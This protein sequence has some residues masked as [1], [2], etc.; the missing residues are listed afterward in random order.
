MWQKSPNSLP[1]R[2]KPTLNDQTAPNLSPDGRFLTYVSKQDDALGDIYWLRLKKRWWLS[3]SPPDRLQRAGW[4]DQ[5]PSWFHQR[6]AIVFQSRKIDQHEPHLWLADWSDELTTRSLNIKGFHPTVSPDDQSIAFT[7]RGHLFLYN[8]T[9]KTQHRLTPDGAFAIIEPQFHPETGD[10]YFIR[11][12]DD[13]NEDGLITT[14]DHGSVW[15]IRRRD[16]KDVTFPPMQPITSAGYDY[17]TPQPAQGRLWVSLRRE[18]RQMIATRPLNEL[19]ATEFRASPNELIQLQPDEQIFRL[20]QL[21]FSDLA[22][23]APMRAAW[24]Q[25]LSWYVHHKKL[26]ELNLLQAELQT[27]ALW[28]RQIQQT[29]QL[30]RQLIQPKTS[31]EPPPHPICATS[32]QSS[33]DR[34]AQLNFGLCWLNQIDSQAKGKQAAIWQKWDAWLELSTKLPFLHQEIVWRRAQYLLDHLGVEHALTSLPGLLVPELISSH[35]GQNIAETVLARLLAKNPAQPLQQLSLYLDRYRNVPWLG[36]QLLRATMARRFAQEANVVVRNEL[37]TL[38]AKS[39]EP[40]LV[41]EALALLLEYDHNPQRFYRLQK[42]IRQA[43]TRL[44][45]QAHPTLLADFKQL[46]SEKF[47]TIGDLYLQNQEPALAIEAFEESRRYRPDRVEVAQ[48]LI[49]AY[50]QKGHL[51]RILNQLAIT[52][53]RRNHTVLDQYLYSYAKTYKIDEAK[54]LDRRLELIDDL[55]SRFSNHADKFRAIPQAQQTRGWLYHQRHLWQEKKNRQDPSWWQAKLKIIDNFFSSSTFDDL[56]LANYYYERAYFHYKP[57]SV[58]RIRLSQNLGETHFFAKNYRKSLLFYRFRLTNLE[59]APF[60]T[61]A[62]HALTLYRAG[63][64]A[65]QQTQLAMATGFLTDASHIWERTKYDREKARS[66]DLLALIYREQGDYKKAAH[67]Y[68]SLLNNPRL[69]TNRA[70][71]RINYAACLLHLQREDEALRELELANESLAQVDEQDATINQSVDFKINLAATETLTQGFDPLTRRLLIATYKISGLT[72]KKDWLTSLE[73]NQQKIRLLA[74]KRQQGL[75]RHDDDSYQ[76][77]ELAL[78]WNHHGRLY[79][80]VGQQQKAQSALEQALGYARRLRQ[81]QVPHEIEWQIVNNLGKTLVH[82][83]QTKGGTKADAAA[84]LQQLLAG[85]KA[86]PDESLTT[87]GRRILSQLARWQRELAEKT[88]LPPTRKQRVTEVAHAWSRHLRQHNWLAAYQA[89]QTESPPLSRQPALLVD[90]LMS[91]LFS[92]RLQLLVES[93]S[94]PKTLI[95]ALQGHLNWRTRHF[96]KATGSV[97]DAATQNLATRKTPDWLEWRRSLAAD[98]GLGLV[99]PLK[100]SDQFLIAF[101]T[102]ESPVQIA[103]TKNIFTWISDQN[104]TS[105]EHVYLNPFPGYQP[106]AQTSYSISWLASG[107]ELATVKAGYQPAIGSLSYN[108]PEPSWLIPRFQNAPITRDDHKVSDLLHLSGMEIPHDL[109]ASRL[110]NPQPTLWQDWLTHLDVRQTIVVERTKTPAPIP[111]DQLLMSYWSL[112]QPIGA[113]AAIIH[114]APS[115]KPTDWRRFYSQFGQ[116]TIPHSMAHLDSDWHLLGA[117]GIPLKTQK[118]IARQRYREARDNLQ[119]GHA[120]HWAEVLGESTL[121]NETLLELRLNAQR[122][123]RF[124]EAF[125]FQNR[126][127][128]ALGDQLVGLDRADEL[129]TAGALALNADEPKKAQ[130]FLTKA[131]E[132][133]QAKGEIWSRAQIPFFQARYAQK[134]GNYEQAIELHRRSRELFLADYDQQSAAMRLLDIA[135]LKKDQLNNY[136]AA[137]DDYRQA[138]EELRNLDDQTNLR[139]LEIDLA[140]TY[141]AMGRIR[142]AIH[143]LKAR[144]KIDIDVA[145]LSSDALRRRLIL[146]NAY[147]RSGELQRGLLL[148]DQLIELQSAKSDLSPSLMIDIWNS[149]ALLLEKLSQTSEAKKYFT[150]ALD[151]AK[152]HKLSG[153]IAQISSNYGYALRENG[154]IEEAITW[155]RRAQSID[156]SL[157]DRKGL[158]FDYRNLALCYILLNQTSK[159]KNLLQQSLRISR[160]LGLTYNR[161]YVELSLADLAM[162]DNR[163]TRAAEYFQSSLKQARQAF[164]QEFI[165]KSLAGLAR[166]ALQQNNPQAGFDLYEQALALIEQLRAQFQSFEVRSQFQADKHIQD[167]YEEYVVALM[168]HDK[169]MRAWEISERS[170]ARAFIDSLANQ[171]IPI[172]NPQLATLVDQVKLAQTRWHK[173]Q[174]LLLSGDPDS[175]DYPTLKQDFSHAQEHYKQLLGDLKDK[176]PQL[177]ATLSIDTIPLDKLKNRL[178]ENTAA[179]EYMVADDRLVI[180]YL[181]QGG[182]EGTTVPVGRHRLRQMIRDYQTLMQNYAQV[183]L[184]AEQLAEILW[185]PFRDSLTKYQRLIVIP[186]A[187]LHYLSFASLKLNDRYLVDQ[188]HLHYW[189]SATTSRFTHEA[190]SPPLRFDRQSKLLALG[191]P[192]LAPHLD[193]PFAG[194][195][196]EV[197]TRY[198][199]NARINIGPQATE[200]LVKRPQHH[201]AM[202]HIASHGVFDKRNP[203]RSALLLTPDQNTDGRLTI[204]DIY[205]LNLATNLVTLSA[206]ETGLGLLK[207]ADEIVSLNRAFIYAGATTIISSLWRINDVAS[208]VIMKRFYRYLSQGLAVDEALSK[209]QQLVRS[210]YTHPAYWAA[211]RIIGRT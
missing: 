130:T 21:R 209:A 156:Q 77:L 35:L 8:L 196:V 201:F 206:C 192:K 106:G 103:T 49:D 98:E 169:V 36:P 86:M 162:R 116:T 180:W 155:F 164:I 45:G 189:E 151:L 33:R 204:E 110:L 122:Q 92:Y 15:R 123:Q 38:L 55:L 211:F 187:E 121:I 170:R 37:D 138:A 178:P 64:A 133:Y 39:H 84:A 104:V 70:I 81:E 59:Q 95:S 165:W 25:E 114:L 166:V 97:A 11:F 135:N 99:W 24:I 109:R 19:A 57:K 82:Q 119:F 46:A 147:Y 146:I 3:S 12:A 200:T 193:L 16:L 160:K 58:A 108:E 31:P 60:T 205:G 26:A 207:G 89:L 67:L 198:F 63:Y 23:Q 125:Y 56:T 41:R 9:S 47:R 94:T 145:E 202:L 52:I 142:K 153:K 143:L 173:A 51:D 126:L 120:L 197:M 91:K 184:M 157:K 50:V 152:S 129:L 61:K 177:F 5:A 161:I 195:E 18:H 20:R 191:N 139:R 132:L 83:A 117:R 44:T 148:N 194:K 158:A 174:R 112:V 136:H 68:K 66:Q 14:Q 30:A 179:L 76:A 1:Y 107:S 149:R 53:Q 27:S 176:D 96:Q 115:R 6:S 167:I 80:R 74:Q 101:F 42:L 10:L 69:Q 163:L 72:Q 34:L 71:Y 190:N 102:A 154:Q 140:N 54:N 13:T 100:T 144:I 62:I 186:H 203:G 168:N 141:L 88:A 4:I 79:W 171:Q 118:T 175:P 105:I 134:Q 210:Y 65:Y 172:D 40:F 17:R 199:P 181:H 185:A 2:L 93:E 124:D 128:Q 150:K 87:E 188:Y 32:L 7:Y 113:T 127:I 43:A 182:I 159:A 85:Y 208:A 29:F 111:P 48:N 73:A 137:L 131:D 78:A 22:S 28:N 183:D 75:N 90:R